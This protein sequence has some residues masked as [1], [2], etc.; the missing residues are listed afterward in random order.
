LIAIPNDKERGILLA[1]RVAR[2]ATADD[3]GRPHVVP[4]CFAYDGRNIFTPVD[5]KKKS[6][7]PGA[8][9]RV[10]NIMSNPRVS[11]VIDGYY[12]DWRRLYYVLIQGFAQILEDGDEYRDSLNIL[13]RKYPQYKKMGLEEAGLPVIKIIPER[14]VSWGGI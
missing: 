7:R 3:S 8:L 6:V 13:A 2:M 10:V 4:V 1:G 9:K 11:L 12:E 14:I 5:K